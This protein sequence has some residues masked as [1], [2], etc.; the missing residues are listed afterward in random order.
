MPGERGE[1]DTVQ[2]FGN[3]AAGYW[4]GASKRRTLSTS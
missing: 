2:R 3:F 1:Q 4:D